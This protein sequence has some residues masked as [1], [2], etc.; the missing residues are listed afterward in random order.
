VSFL[1]PLV[2]FDAIDDDTLNRCLVAWRHKMGPLHRPK[3]GN[4]GGAHGLFHDGQ[5]VAVLATSTMIAAEMCGLSRNEAFELARVCAARPGLCRVAVRLWRE[6][7]FP[8]V[9]ASANMSWAISY[10]DAVQHRGDL[11]RHDG[12]ARIGQTSSGTD[13]RGRD[14]TR[15]GRR[16]VVWGWTDDAIALAAR[17]GDVIGNAVVAEGRLCGKGADGLAC[18][19]L[20][21]D[22]ISDVLK[23]DRSTS[24]W[25]DLP[26][27]F[28]PFFDA[29]E[30]QTAR[31]AR[32]LPGRPDAA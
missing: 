32:E 8:A 10:Q 7:V 14:G 6:F 19:D 11:Y 26:D 5:L 16:K 30:A 25:S 24:F 3:Y 22:F 4:L 1:Q 13:Q 17:R 9:A 31:P 15:R 21:D 18:A 23:G 20:A 12:W 28:P 2:N 29:H 27:A